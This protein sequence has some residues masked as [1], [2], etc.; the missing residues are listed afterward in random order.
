MN[1]TLTGSKVEPAPSTKRSTTQIVLSLVLVIVTA[2]AAFFFMRQSALQDK[3]AQLQAS[4][5]QARNE[6]AKLQ[7]QLQEA[8]SDGTKL[9]SQ[10]Q[11]VRSDSAKLQT[12]L[13]QALSEIAKM[14][15]LAAKALEMP[16]K[17]GFR[18]A[19]L[20]DGFVAVLQN[21]STKTLSV[22]VK[23][24]DA[25]TARSREFRVVMDGFDPGRHV[26]GYPT[27]EI[28]HQEG[29]AFASGDKLQL[30]C[31]GYDR[32]ERTVP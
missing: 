29:W 17:I 27:K 8:R 12:Q 21:T 22:D 10:L 7:S 30:S 11:A 15:P 20:G 26:G 28:G 24:T 2:A 5:D 13:E 25:T 23:C 32:K 19:I 9:Q 14:Q 1:E 4:M 6:A 18:K 31:A 3:A 16:V